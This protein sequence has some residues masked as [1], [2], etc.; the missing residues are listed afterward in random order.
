MIADRA[1]DQV[2][3]LVDNYEPYDGPG[4]LR[5]QSVLDVFN[6]MRFGTE[7]S[8]DELRKRML[9]ELGHSYQCNTVNKAFGVIRRAGYPIDNSFSA[10]P[11]GGFWRYRM[12]RPAG[13]PA[14]ISAPRHPVAPKP[15]AAGQSLAHAGRIAEL[16][17]MIRQRQ[18]ALSQYP[19]NHTERMKSMPEIERFELE[20]RS[21]EGRLGCPV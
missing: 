9:T 18:D 15:A 10:T 14:E 17:E 20:L 5:R 7:F 4:E 16:R 13:I 8:H 2:P 12:L 6:T 3:L 19:E 11:A 21:L 1:I